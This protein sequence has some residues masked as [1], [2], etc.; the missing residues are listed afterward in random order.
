MDNKTICERCQY[1]GQCKAIRINANECK[2]HIDTLSE[3][4]AYKKIYEGCKAELKALI[5]EPIDSITTKLIQIKIR[6]T[7]Q[8]YSKS[9]KNNK[10]PIVAVMQSKKD[11]RNIKIRVTNK[12]L[13]KGETK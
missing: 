2:Y 12:F 7:I 5:G 8:G 11:K 1:E 9:F 4:E 10:K 3:G 6:H 13:L